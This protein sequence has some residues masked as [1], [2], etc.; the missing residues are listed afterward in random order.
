[1]CITKGINIA[2]NIIIKRRLLLFISI[3]RGKAL[4]ANMQKY[5]YV[6]PK[7]MVCR[8]V[9]AYLLIKICKFHSACFIIHYP[10]SKTDLICVGVKKLNHFKTNEMNR[11]R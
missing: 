4:C 2:Q 1:M 7:G 9:K 10:E 6:F 11:V 5:G 8:V 3:F